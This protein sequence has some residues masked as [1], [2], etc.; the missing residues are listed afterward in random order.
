MAN[1]YVMRTALIWPRLVAQAALVTELEVARRQ[2]D[3]AD[4]RA[5]SLEEEVRTRPCHCT[6]R[7]QQ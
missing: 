3:D 6:A 5:A 4:L 7:S 1:T 2:R